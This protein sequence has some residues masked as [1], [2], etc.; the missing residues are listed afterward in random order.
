MGRIIRENRQV[1]YR[2]IV[3]QRGRRRRSRSRDGKLIQARATRIDSAGGKRGVQ[4]AR[5]RGNLRVLG[6][7]I[8]LEKD[9][10]ELS[11]G[12]E[13]AAVDGDLSLV[14]QGP[15]GNIV[16]DGGNG[17]GSNGDNGIGEGP[18]GRLRDGLARV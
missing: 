6:N 9:T 5:G 17:G 3:G 8:A 16:G 7:G 15:L 18:R 11:V 10:G 2:R 1:H 13:I 12:S 4:L 14:F